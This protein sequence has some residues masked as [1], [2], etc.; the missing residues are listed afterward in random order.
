MTHSLLW[1]Q[2]QHYLHVKLCACQI[3]LQTLFSDHKAQQLNERECAASSKG[4]EVGD[5]HDLRVDG[6]ALIY[7]RQ[8]LDY[9]ATPWLPVDATQTLTLTSHR[10]HST[11]KLLDVSNSGCKC[12]LWATFCCATFGD[13]TTKRMKS[14]RL[15]VSAMHSAVQV[16]MIWQRNRWRVS[17]S[18]YISA[19]YEQYS[20][21]WLSVIWQQNRWKVSNSGC[22]GAIYE[23][24]SAL[25]LSMIWQQTWWKVSYPGCNCYLWATCLTFDGLTMKAMKRFKLW[26]QVLFISNIQLSDFWWSDNET[27]EKSV[28]N[29]NDR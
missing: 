3:P 20:A 4:P 6:S 19:I 21:V 27:G 29:E 26:I 7:T 22:I 14:F 11:K 8:C 25:Q 16:F 24:H 2:D 13:L 23:Q 9:R 12:Y 15:D 5:S 18:G 28:T 17:D 1:T 10:S